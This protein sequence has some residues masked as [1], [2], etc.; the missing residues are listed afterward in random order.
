MTNVRAA[1]RRASEEIEDV[2][3]TTPVSDEERLAGIAEQL[4]YLA[5]GDP[6]DPEALAF[7]DPGALDT[8]R[9]HLSD[10]IEEADG[11]AATRLER[12]R[13]EI[14]L[15]ISTLDDKLEKQRA[16]RNEPG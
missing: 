16:T 3:E 12:T 11:D 14:L 10:A 2:C 13:D 7:P 15:A 9:D 5:E 1:L 8:I 6:R 4:R